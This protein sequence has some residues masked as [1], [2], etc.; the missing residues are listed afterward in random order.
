MRTWLQGSHLAS[1]AFLLV[2]AHT[3]SAAS[4]SGD[5]P[6]LSGLDDRD[7]VYILDLYGKGRQD[8]VYTDRE[9]GSI[10]LRPGRAWNRGFAEEQAL[11][12]SLLHPQAGMAFCDLDGDGDQDL[13]YQNR[14][15]SDGYYIIHEIRWLENLGRRD[16][17]AEDRVLHWEMER[18]DLAGMY[19]F[20]KESNPVGLLL[21]GD[22]DQDGDPDLVYARFPGIGLRWLEQL[23]APDSFHVSRPIPGP[24]AEGRSLRLLDLDADGDLDLV[25]QRKRS[26]V[27]CWAENQGALQ[28]FSPF[29]PLVL[30]SEDRPGKIRRL[31]AWADLNGDQRLD[32]LGTVGRSR[33][34]AVLFTRPPY[35]FEKAV[36]LPVDPTCRH[37]LPLDLD[38]DGD[39]DLLALTHSDAAL[40]RYENTD[41][42]G[43]FRLRDTLDVYGLRIRVARLLTGKKN[44]SLLLTST[45][46]EVFLRELKD[47]PSWPAPAVIP[48]EAPI[49]DG[50]GPFAA[51]RRLP[52][53]HRFR[54]LYFFACDQ[55][56][57]GGPELGFYRNSRTLDGAELPF[58]KRAPTV[59][60][61]F[62]PVLDKYIQCV[63]LNGDGVLD[64]LVA[65][66]TTGVY[67]FA[68][69]P[70]TEA[71]GP[72]QEIG[73]RLRMPTSVCSGDLDGDGAPDVLLSLSLSNEVL[74]F[75]NRDG[76]GAFDSP[77]V[78]TDQAQ[79]ADHVNCADLDMDGDLD[80]LCASNHD[81]TFSWFENTDG[82]GGFG[83]R[84]FVSRKSNGAFHIQAVDL[85]GDGDP[86][87]LGA[88]RWGATIAW[89][90]N[91]DGRGTFGKAQ[92]I[93]NREIGLRPLLCMDLD[94][95][96]DA[97]ILAG[98]RD[99]KGLDAYL[100]DGAG[101]FSTLPIVRAEEKRVLTLCCMD[102]DGD[103][104]PDLF[105]VP[106][107]PLGE[108]PV[109]HL[110]RNLSADIR[111]E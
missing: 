84:R 57:D 15:R 98:H 37:L 42:A 95:D 29:H 31:W 25:G 5:T 27:L 64:R 43:S 82:K 36:D 44:P 21:P 93:S 111:L 30:D 66:P 1:A 90:E 58:G 74:W 12:D 68:A 83:S 92:E 18:Y 78:I 101:N 33:R 106:R 87:L 65:N 45:G 6:L 7:S 55:D 52:F 47:V 108:D 2:F 109:L 22:L 104:D 105:T 70:G 99:S 72:Q 19:G 13:L 17:F 110:Y 4:G 86:D 28:G 91:R 11:V 71:W 34:S 73:N 46:G 67:W 85:D 38:E 96:G 24:G 100:N 97:D 62:N 79:S 54:P 77:R 80:V 102:V 49:V 23:A 88:S 9:S 26:E 14:Y 51:H 75:R 10:L 3:A 50:A 59:D 81:D 40:L 53:Q 20:S 63:D 8:L 35:G 103:G 39:L 107:V 89:W 41:G 16:G 32:A 56:G 76:K 61:P 60:T 69:D 48:P 94:L